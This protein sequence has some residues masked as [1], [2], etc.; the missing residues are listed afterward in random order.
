MVSKRRSLGVKK[1]LLI[2]AARTFV[3]KTSPRVELSSRNCGIV[4]SKPEDWDYVKITRRSKEYYLCIIE[5]S[6]VAENEL[7]DDEL[8]L[9]A[10]QVMLV[11]WFCY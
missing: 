1:I 9:N 4:K 6:G 2:M 7:K 5:C 11:C 10:S 8:G 3:V